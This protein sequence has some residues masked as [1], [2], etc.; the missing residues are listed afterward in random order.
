MTAGRRTLRWT[1]TPSVRRPGSCTESKPTTFNASKGWFDKFQ[2]RFKLKSV[3]LYGEA[4]SVDKPATEGYVKEKF[5]TVEEGG[6]S[7]EQVS[8]M[9]ETGRFCNRMPTRT[10][11]IKEEARAP[12]FKAC[13]E[14]VAIIMCG[15]IKEEQEDPGEEEEV[16][17]SLE[18][19]ST[20]AKTAKELQRKAEEWDPQM[21]RALQLRNAIDEAMEVYKNLLTLK[22]RYGT[23]RL[24][25]CWTGAF[26][27][28]AMHSHLI[29]VITCIVQYCTANYQRHRVVS[30]QV[31]VPNFFLS[32]WMCL[33][34]S[35]KDSPKKSFSNILLC[36]CDVSTMHFLVW[37]M[38]TL[39][40]KIIITFIVHL[41]DIYTSHKEKPP[42]SLPKY[43]Y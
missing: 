1:P 20:L 4:A 19:L 33:K 26:R 43:I 2:K 5:K 40:H 18:R 27:S 32:F 23:T 41:F 3:S 30:L 37:I 8:N 10:F 25:D 16:G 21:I 13:K 11:I 17:L 6:Y 12:G 42:S 15:K 36:M 38:M 22:K 29:I 35:L 14:S 34:V 31:S 7:G 9:D 39:G 28:Y 24:S